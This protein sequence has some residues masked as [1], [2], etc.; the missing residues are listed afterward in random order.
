MTRTNL[1]NVDL[2]RADKDTSTRVAE[3]V[4]C[5]I[6]KKSINK[7]YKDTIESLEN[8]IANGE[9]SLS[10]IPQTLAGSIDEDKIPSVLEAKKVEIDGYRKSLADTIK[11]RDEQIAKEATF[12]FTTADNAFKKALKG[13]ELNDPKVEEEVIKWFS[14][15]GIDVSN[16]VLL[17]DILDAIGGK[18]DFNRL[19]DSEGLDGVSVDNS[20]ALSMLYWIAFRHMA[21]VGTIKSAQIPENIRENFGKVARDKKKAEKKA[22]KAAKK[23]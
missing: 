10:R 5:R 23:N 9:E 4:R 19:V 6:M 2:F 18:E 22:K 20:R 21:T 3:Y 17:F 15:Y 12:A 1:I 11:K 13:L 8:E 16:S 14:N 7:S